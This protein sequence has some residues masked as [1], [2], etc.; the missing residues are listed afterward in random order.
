MKMEQSV[1]KRRHINFRRRGI[2]QKIANNIPYTAKFWNQEQK[3]FIIQ[4]IDN[5]DKVI[6]EVK[7]QHIYS[8]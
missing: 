8:H 4:L 7:T 3:Y 5:N 6:C 2:T 1:P